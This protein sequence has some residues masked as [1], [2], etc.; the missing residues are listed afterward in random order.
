LRPPLRRARFGAD[1]FADSPCNPD[2][3]AETT[4][5]HS[6]KAALVILA[7]VLEAGVKW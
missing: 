4:R 2:D 7:R 1:A 6:I 5:M 3:A